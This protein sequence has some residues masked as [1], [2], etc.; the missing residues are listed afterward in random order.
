V[1]QPKHYTQ[2]DFSGGEISSRMLMRADTVMYAKSLLAMENFIPTLQGTAE[3]APGSRFLV[4]TGVNAAR[5]IPYRTPLNEP[6]VVEFKAG[7][8]PVIHR[9]FPELLEDGAGLPGVQDPQA[10]VIIRRFFIQNGFFTTGLDNWTYSPNTVYDPDTGKPFGVFWGEKE[11][12]AFMGPR[13]YNP[14]DPNVATMR[15][16]CTLTTATDRITMFYTI[17][18]QDAIPFNSGYDGFLTVGTTLDGQDVFRRDF[19][20]EVTTEWTHNP[21]ET[22]AIPGGLGVPGQVLYVRIQF[23]AKV[24][25]GEKYSGPLFRVRVIQIRANQS[26]DTV[27]EAVVNNAPY[28]ADQLKDLHYIQNPYPPRR[29]LVVVHPEHPPYRLHFSGG[30]YTFEPIDF[31][32]FVPPEWA[33]DG[34]YP[35]T[36]SSFHGRLVMAGSNFAPVIGAIS[37]NPTEKV[38]LTEV[39]VWDRFTDPVA[40]VTAKDS[41]EFHTIY[42]SPI[43]WVFGQ[44]VL[45]IGAQEMEYVASAETVFQPAD[46]GVEMHS[47]HGSSSVQ[48]V[49]LGKSVMF[50]AEGGTKVRSMMASTED[51]GYIAPDMTLLNPEICSEGIVRMA[52]LRNP[53]QMV[54]VVLEQGQIAL[55][56]QDN[57]TGLQ[58]WSRL[59]VGGGAVVDACVQP[60]TKGIDI[61]YLLVRRRIGGVYTLVIEAIANWR[62]VGDLDYV[63]SAT[64]YSFEDPTNTFTGLEHLEGL[65]VQVVSGTDYIGQYQVAGGEITLVDQI[66]Q[67]ILLSEAVIGLPSNCTLVTLPPSTPDEGAPKRYS[68]ISVRVRGSTRP[69]INGQRP[70]DRT[71]ITPQ[72]NSEATDDLRDLEVT[73][74]DWDTY[75]LIT[76]TE[77]VPLRVEI[78]GIYGKLKA[79][80]I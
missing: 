54:V 67:P 26:L 4:D 37:E 48:A 8:P 43:Q 72:T 68:D 75:Q 13:I 60:D 64:K 39:G 30:T 6:A 22:F 44:K 11:K 33:V 28:T 1:A 42:R 46:I 10:P 61:L 17:Q 74:L 40:V 45:M 27:P 73:N 58:G 35:R 24:S 71:P 14:G 36:C 53:H 7:V 41:M 21:S 59:D 79:G 55:F 57:Y 34:N 52:R 69:F 12:D 3:R 66:G 29:E 47:T 25:T 38:W 70:D 23:T 77:S 63:S 76:I 62:E 15:T 18:F 80:D 32:S 20:G 31:G 2:R 19:T 51:G 5:I 9:A 16:S 65:F 56:H 78:L 49:G 50:A